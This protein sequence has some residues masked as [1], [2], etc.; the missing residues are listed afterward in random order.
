MLLKR[1][2]FNKKSFFFMFPS[3]VTPQEIRFRQFIWAEYRSGNDEKQALI[4]I[5]A[6]LGPKSASE[7]T[8]EHWYQRFRSNKRSLFEQYDIT[9]VVQTFSNGKE[10]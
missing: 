3:M 1:F 2:K 5:N 9:P 8:I 4:N 10:V 6:K 7:S